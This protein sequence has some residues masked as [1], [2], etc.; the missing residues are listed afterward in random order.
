[1]SAAWHPDPF[2][3]AQFRYYDGT[4]WTRHVATNGQ[5][6]VEAP[7]LPLIPPAQQFYAPP[8]PR[9]ERPGSGRLIA[10]GVM[11]LISAL[12][13][14]FLSV[15]L[16]VIVSDPGAFNNC[17]DTNY[18]CERIVVTNPGLVR[19][20][21]S[22]YAVLAVL[23][24]VAGVGGCMRKYWGQIA[25]IVVGVLGMLLFLLPII[26]RGQGVAAVPVAWFGLI[27]GLAAATPKSIYK[28]T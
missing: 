12:F 25:L 24:L 20:L 14:V 2:A 9:P 1:M 15:V 21:A 4:A 3:R 27:A 18:G 13:T 10:A 23:L 19:T 5:Q 22:F 8:V 17:A 7:D 26:L 16:F 11:A 28:V 6:S